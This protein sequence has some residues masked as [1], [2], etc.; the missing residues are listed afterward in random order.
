MEDEPTLT[1]SQWKAVERLEKAFA[2]CV[3]AGVV[4]IGMDRDMYCYDAK[5]FDKLE[6]MADPFSPR[7]PEQSIKIDTH[8][9]YKDSGGW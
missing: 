5:R 8:G 6:G 2:A 3:K 9:A 4:F 1:V 7:W